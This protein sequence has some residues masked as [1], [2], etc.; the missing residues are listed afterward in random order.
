MEEEKKEP[1]LAEEAGLPESWH[2]ISS[3]PVIPGATAPM[4]NAMANQFA[5]PLSPSIQ[6]DVMF[7]GTALGTPAIAKLPL[8]PVAPSGLP[9]DNAAIKSFTTLTGSNTTTKVV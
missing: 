3:E 4:P 8:L 1:T 2:P 7:V 9:Q 5:G 6:H